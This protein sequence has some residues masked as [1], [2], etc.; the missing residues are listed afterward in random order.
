VSQ[1]LAG[2]TAP[3]IP[4]TSSGFA[5]AWVTKA[6]AAGGRPGARVATVETRRVGEGVGVLAEL[7]QLRLT[8]EPGGV[9]PASVI[10]KL[11]ASNPEVRTLCSAYGFYEREMRFYR[12][13]AAHIELRTPA[14]YFS[15]FDPATGDCVILMEDLAPA[16]SPD[17][18]AGIA[19]DELTAAIDGIADLHARW[20]DDP[21]LAE[22]RCV[23]P[24]AADPPYCHVT[25][26]YRASLPVALEGLRALG[27]H[28]L[29]RVADRLDPAIA[30]LLAAMTAE[31]LTLNHGDFRVDNLMFRRGPA[32]L[33]LTVVDWQIVM[34]VRGPFD[35]GYL[36]GGAAPTVLRR[37]EETRLLRRYHDRLTG[38]GVT[39]YS[40]EDCRLDYR[41]AMLFSLAYWV[42]GYPV[43]DKEN[44]RAAALFD[45]WARRLDAAVRDLDLEDLVNG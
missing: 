6:L 11:H 42:E 34:Q 19:L 15:D 37:A 2:E 5:P 10:A 30:R 27:L 13:V 40:L 45:S 20:W 3:P 41:R 22:L 8:Y 31:P 16:A 24:S 33:A 9:G 14:H 26:T 17:Q 32:G 7:Y 35:L 44:P 1:V 21:R 36:M 12:D 4:A 39:G 18:I 25:E 43:A 23:M 29:A 28:D 38:R